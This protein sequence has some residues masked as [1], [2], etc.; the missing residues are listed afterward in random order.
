MPTSIF[1]PSGDTDDEVVDPEGGGGGGIVY[2]AVF[3]VGTFVDP[4]IPFSIQ[5]QADGVNVSSRVIITLLAKQG[6]NPV[7]FTAI[8][9]D[10]LNIGQQ[11]FS[12]EYLS[13]DSGLI[14]GEWL[15]EETGPLTLYALLGGIII[16]SAPIPLPPAP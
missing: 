2:T 12:A 7:W 6:T 16:G 14:Q 10:P 1:F 4:R 8:G 13:N 9:I 15:N 3:T 11:I 5:I